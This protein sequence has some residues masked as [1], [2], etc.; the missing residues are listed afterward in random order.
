MDTIHVSSLYYNEYYL[1]N[2]YTGHVN[3]GSCSLKLFHHY[4]TGVMTI[5][6]RC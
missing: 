2:T 6:L 1:Y 4:E 5:T 3:V